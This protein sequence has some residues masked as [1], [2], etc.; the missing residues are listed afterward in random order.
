[1]VSDFLRPVVRHVAHDDAFF[2]RSADV[3]V[4]ESDPRT[5]D[6]DALPCLFEGAVAPASRI[7][8]GNVAP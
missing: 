8:G 7:I 6:S 1:M 4:V 5:N 3:N 2:A